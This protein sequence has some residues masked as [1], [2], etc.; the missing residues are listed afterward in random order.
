MLRDMRTQMNRLQDVAAGNQQ[1]EEDEVQE[2]E[3]LMEA[4]EQ[5]DL[6]TSRLEKNMSAIKQQVTDLKAYLDS[7]QGDHQGP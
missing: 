4:L 1:Q 5:L 7:Q 6:D 3:G 2:E